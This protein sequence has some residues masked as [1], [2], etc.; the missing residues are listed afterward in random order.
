MID[1]SNPQ[2]LR[3]DLLEHVG[4]EIECVTYGNTFLEPALECVTCGCILLVVYE[5]EDY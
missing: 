1:T 5:D 2:Q 4:H 3:E